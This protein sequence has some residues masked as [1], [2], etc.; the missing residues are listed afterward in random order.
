MTID[1][2]LDLVPWERMRE[3]RIGR[4]RRVGSHRC[5]ICVVWGGNNALAYWRALAHG[6]DASDAKSVIFAADGMSSPL[7]DEMV[8]RIRAAQGLRATP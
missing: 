5:P 1:D 2:F 4:I 6:M 3:T 8:Y 7:R